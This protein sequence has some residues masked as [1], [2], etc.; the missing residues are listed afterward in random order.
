VHF[1]DQEVVRDGNIITSRVPGDLPAFM[2]AIIS[3]LQ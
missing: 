2:K 1:V 3:Y